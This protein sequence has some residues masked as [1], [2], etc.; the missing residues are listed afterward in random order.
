M[1]LWYMLAPLDLSSCHCNVEKRGE[2]LKPD[3]RVMSVRFRV[4]ANF[5]KVDESQRSPVGQVAVL[6]NLVTD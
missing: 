4:S 5:V 6:R 2:Q 1:Y 3:N